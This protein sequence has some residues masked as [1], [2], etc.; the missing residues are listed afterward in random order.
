MVLALTTQVTQQDNMESAAKLPRPPFLLR[1]SNARIAL[2]NLTGRCVAGS[3]EGEGVGGGGVPPWG[4]PSC[5][6]RG[7][8]ALEV[9]R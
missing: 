2:L 4:G 3:G 5:P 8:R 1:H 9:V 7:G 6:W